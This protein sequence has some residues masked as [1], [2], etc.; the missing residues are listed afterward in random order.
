MT[1]PPWAFSAE[2]GLWKYVGAQ[3]RRAGLE[4]L[5]PAAVV[6]V[7]AEDLARQARRQVDR[8]GGGDPAA[9]WPSSR[10]ALRSAVTW[11]GS[12]VEQDAAVLAVRPS[13]GCRAPGH[14]LG[15][16]SGHRRSPAAAGPVEPDVH[17]AG[18]DRVLVLAVRPG[19]GAATAPSPS[20]AIII[21]Y[22]PEPGLGPVVSET[23][24]HRADDPGVVAGLQPGDPLGVGGAGRRAS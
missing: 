12:A 7:Y 13:A 3:R 5:D 10:L 23:A 22:V 4:T 19:P 8:L 9:V 2:V 14:G 11:T 20:A 18:A 6:Q 21:R 15:R 17:L 1:T 16:W 24:C